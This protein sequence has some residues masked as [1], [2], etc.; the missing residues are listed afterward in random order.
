M[1]TLMGLTLFVGNIGGA[2]G[3]WVGGKVFDISGHY[4]WAFI[5]AAVACLGAF[6]TSF[7]LK[8]QGQTKIKS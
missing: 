3:P 4:Q 2:L 8:R 7:I 5:I 6:I 1:A